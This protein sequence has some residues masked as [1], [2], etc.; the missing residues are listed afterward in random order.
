MTD[1]PIIPVP[2]NPAQQEVLDLLGAPAEAR[3]TFGPGLRDSL[4]ADLEDGLRDLAPELDPDDPLF[5]SKHTLSTVHGCEARFMAERQ[6]PFAWSAPLARGTVAHKAIELSIHWRGRPDP[7]D[8]VDEALARLSQGT[9]GLGDWLAR[10]SEAE[11]AELRG[12][13]NERVA[14]FLECFPPL[15]TAWVPVTEGRLRTELLGGRVILA[16]R[17]DL[18]LGRPEGTTARKVIIDLK[19][20]G[21]SASHLD[22]LRF[23]ALVETLRLGTPPRLVASYHLDAGRAIPEAVTEGSLRAAV[24]RTVDGARALHELTVGTRA[25][26][27]RPGHT[28][29]WCPALDSCAVGRAHLGQS[30]DASP[31]DAD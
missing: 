5:I 25:P 16:G 2:L 11:R 31:F 4:R 7:L 1:A 29:R 20:G 21:F 8:L 22:D 12:L 15:R 6:I 30:E 24:A 3:P 28:C 17:T 18:A 14:T 23:Y 19:T 10:C 26:T 13:A 9:D 27:A